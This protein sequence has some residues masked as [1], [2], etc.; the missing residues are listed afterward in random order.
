MNFAATVFRAILAGVSCAA[1]Q[2]TLAQDQIEI[3]RFQTLTFP[4]NLFTSLMPPLEDGKAATVF[5]ILRM[6]AGAESV[7]A[8]ILVH[9]CGGIT[10]SETYWARSLREFG[11]AT[12]LVNSFT[13]RDIAQICTGQPSISPASV[14]TD[15][16]RA[17][18]L[19]AS[20]P[21][22]DASRVALMGFSFGGRMTLWAN[23]LRFH[24][25]YGRGAAH[26]AAYLAFYPASCY[27]R[28]A[29]EEGIGQAPIRI[30][31]GTSDDWTPINP[32]REYVGRLR[33]ARKNVAM[34]EYPGAGHG[35]DNSLSSPPQA[36]PGVVNPSRCAFVEREGKIVDET[37]RL[38]GFD[39]PCF[40][41]GA[42]IG[43]SPDAHR[44]AVVDVHNFLRAVF[45]LK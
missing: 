21:R 37:G 23:H 20:Y 43:Y 29:D 3:V 26:F 30:F 13:G 2:T 45:R 16:Y 31:H 39:S 34:F 7:P 1:A 5:G 24:E 10:G 4:G 44:Q 42:S 22:I 18:D 14:L 6:P 35:F 11:I 9:A 40:F 33:G 36:L 28:L 12:L 15:V 32:C 41:R 25:R 27:I 38:A 17:L 8:V 19:L